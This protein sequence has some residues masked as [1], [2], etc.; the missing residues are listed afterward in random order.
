MN[1]DASAPSRSAA[2][3]RGWHWFEYLIEASGL[4]LFMIAASAFACLVFHPDSPLARAVADP[5]TRRALMGA[6]MAATCLV[7]VHSPWGKRSGAHFNPALTLAFWRLGRVAPHDTWAYLSAQFIGGTAGMMGASLVAG[8]WLA[9][10]A[11][12]FVATTPGPAGAGAAWVGEFL[13]AATLMT[14]VLATSASKHW[15]ASTGSFAALLVFLFITFESPISGMSLN[16]ARSF[17]SSLVSGNWEGWWIYA[18]AP[19]AGMLT[20]AHAFR[21]PR[22]DRS[23]RCARLQPGGPAPCL[24]CQYQNATMRSPEVPTV[25]NTAPAPLTRA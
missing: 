14:M 16:P 24:F 15:H 1:P 3:H 4:G 9:H 5:L 20:A 23:P 13:M 21:V 11:V 6:A 10:P 8:E 12:G 18:S 22:P 17:A 19:V 7:L 2:D 25:R